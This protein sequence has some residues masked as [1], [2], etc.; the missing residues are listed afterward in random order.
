M[1]I[2]KVDLNKLQTYSGKTTHSFEQLIYSLMKKE[3]GEMGRFTA[4]AGEGGDSGVEFYLDLPNGERWGWQC[5]WYDDNGRLGQSSRYASIGSSLETACANHAN[6]TKWFLCLRTNLTISTVTKTGK[7]KKGE[8]EW[9]E[10]I[11]PSKI[12]HGKSVQLDF[13]GEDDI[14][15]LIGN[16]KNAGVRSF[17]FGEL[18]FNQQWFTSKFNDSF[19]QVKDKYE[20]GLHTM[21]DFVHSIIDFKLVN[22]SYTSLLDA[23]SE[24]LNLIESD[25]CTEL[26]LFLAVSAHDSDE[27]EQKA[28]GMNLFAE[29]DKHKYSTYEIL[30]DI[31]KYIIEYDIQALKNLEFDCSDSIF[32]EYLRRVSEY[33][34][35]SGESLQGPAK[36]TY[37]A[38]KNFFEELGRFTSNYIHSLDNEIHFIAKPAEGKTHTSCDIAYKRIQAGLPAIFL[39]GDKFN[40]ETNLEQTILKLLD[41]PVNYS[42]EDLL[43]ALDIYGS[44]AKVRI[45]VIIDGLNETV[46]NKLFS[47]IWKTHLPTLSSKIKR[48]Q[49]L[50]LITTCRKSYKDE[51]WPNSNARSFHNLN[52]FEGYG[53]TKEAIEKYFKKYHITA[54]LSFSYLDSFKKPI[55]LRLYCEIK[56]PNWQSGIEV[57]VII[58]DDSS[59]SLFETYFAQINTAVTLK[60]HLLRKNEQFIQTNL[61]KIARYLWENSA[62]EIAIE[63]YFELI[64]GSGHYN[65]ETSRADILIREGLIITRDLRSEKEFIS[66]TYELMS[67]YLIA[68]Y[69]IDNISEED[70]LPH[71]DFH[72]KISSET[73]QHPLYENI[74][75][76]LALL[77]P[78]HKQKM[79]H[80]LYP[81][82]EDR[83]IHSASVNALWKLQPEYIR[84]EDI[85]L[86]RGYFREKPKSRPHIIS[87]CTDTITSTSHPLNVHFLSAELLNLAVWERDLSWTAHV[88]KLASSLMQYIGQFEQ[89]CKSKVLESELGA[90]KLHLAAQYIQWF[91]VSTNRQLRDFS[92]RALYYYG[93]KY[94][95][96]YTEITLSSLSCNDPYL[97][98]RT[99]AVLYG[100]C[101][102]THHNKDF[103]QNCLP[104]IGN[105]I[106]ELMFVEH[107]PHY[108]TH[109]L[110]RDYASRCIRI[111]LIHEPNLLTDSQ[112]SRIKSPYP[113]NGTEPP[114]VEDSEDTTYR[115]PLG[116]DFSNYTIGYIVKGGHSYSNPPEK[117]KVRRQI[118]HRVDQ[119]GW[120]EDR[121]KSVEDS[122]GNDPYNRHDRPA[123]ERYGKKYLRTAF[124]EIAGYRE[125]MGLL[126]DDFPRFR[127]S[128]TDLD[129]SFPEPPKTEKLVTVDLLGDRS[130]PLVDWLKTDD[131]PNI[132][133]YLEP[134][135]AGSHQ[136]V[137]M[138]GYIM[139][140]E[141]TSCRERFA[142]IR[143]L[144]VK[145]DEYSELLARISDQS[146]GGR[147]LPEKHENTDAFAGEIYVFEEATY[148]NMTQ[149]EFVLSTTEKTVKRGEEGYEGDSTFKILKNGSFSVKKS[150]PK[151]K[152]ITVREIKEFEVLMPVMNYHGPSD[153][154]EINKASSTTVLAKEIAMN[155]GLVEKAQ[156][157]NLFDAAWEPASINIDYYEDHNNTH[158]M[159]YLR[160]DL[161]N[162]YLENKGLKFF[163]AIWG[164][165]E[166]SSG[167][168]RATDLG[169]GNKIEAYFEFQKIIEYK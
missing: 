43:T 33:A 13:I 12:P 49:N 144:L 61:S 145:K 107:A 72:K 64:D 40:H 52:G 147:W 54:D 124:F 116:M 117:Q 128:S 146:L 85:A 141:E 120:T 7:P 1:T 114:M 28:A 136:F 39:T 24:K 22:Q 51:V 97:W 126:Q 58:D 156:T 50:V 132:E 11:L 143:G 18:E 15:T 92:T 78:K 102:A 123:V 110:A 76:E 91:L 5:K 59:N 154:K 46:H 149:L 44:L 75:E 118:L 69:L 93:R 134:K 130:L 137:C 82:T 20:P 94:Y 60:S 168:R 56:N 150:Y 133:Q 74:I 112:H 47:T 68:K 9:F 84:E 161:L 90:A 86:V 142:F 88:Q 55:F 169:D 38:V 105:S 100:M 81:L 62:R 77:F 71:S 153:N 103:Q 53:V 99:L 16:V 158:N 8:R 166:P 106:Y 122:F 79:L 36:K 23:Y 129:P 121:F 32:N 10:K 80:D 19:E 35:S 155:L 26:K 101:M 6:L 65:E 63:D 3:Y 108:T 87:M 140:N 151:T 131:F 41:T 159:V 98:E 111:A 125:D 83:E 139:Q 17:F 45:P 14:I 164:E 157:F 165:R 30:K 135:L 89:Q 104:K 127:I 42:F 160:K 4:I 25:I 37:F 115:A 31:K 109:V 152:T 163:W 138:D 2:N 70:L 21:D 95:R 167:Y 48:F 66:I 34:Y 27:K 162:T 148:S 67:G 29:F 57:E 113:S 119:F 73:E 96:Q